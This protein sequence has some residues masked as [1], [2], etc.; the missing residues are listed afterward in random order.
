MFIYLVSPRSEY[1]TMR[2]QMRRFTV[3]VLYQLSLLAGILLFPVAMVLQ[4][5]GITLPVGQFVNRI[6]SAYAGS[7]RRDGQAA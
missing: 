1:V 7:N 5:A 2:S 4:R 3:F 6:Y